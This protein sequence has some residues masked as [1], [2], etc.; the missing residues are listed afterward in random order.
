MTRLLP[1]VDLRA[2]RI[3]LC[4]QTSVIPAK[5]G[6]QA[7]GL[8]DQVRRSPTYFKRRPASPELMMK[9]SAWIPVFAG[10]TMDAGKG[11]SPPLVAVDV[12]LHSVVIRGPADRVGCWPTTGRK[13]VGNIGKQTGRGP[14]AVGIQW[15]VERGAAQR[16]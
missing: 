16:G 11:Q 2:D 8:C 4:R 9:S 3:W 12:R 10:M 6:I 14:I 5:A 13:G 15:R 1:L 7:I